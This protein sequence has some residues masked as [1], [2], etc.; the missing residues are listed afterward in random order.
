MVTIGKSRLSMGWVVIEV[1]MG[2]SCQAKYDLL[3]RY[4]APKNPTQTI[5]NHNSLALLV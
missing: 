3:I 1:A 4:P 2:L 5:P